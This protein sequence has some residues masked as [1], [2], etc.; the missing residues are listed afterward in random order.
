MIFAS[1][2]KWRELRVHKVGTYGNQHILEAPPI[3][4]LPT[5]WGMNGGSAWIDVGSV[6]SSFGIIGSTTMYLNTCS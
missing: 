3:R 6:G 5:L 1:A 4:K 2:G